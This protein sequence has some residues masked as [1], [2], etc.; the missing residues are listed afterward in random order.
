ML[1][2]LF[3]MMMQ[4]MDKQLFFEHMFGKT[5]IRIDQIPIT[6]IDEMVDAVVV[7]EKEQLLLRGI[8][9]GFVEVGFVRKSLENTVLVKKRESCFLHKMNS[10]LFTIGEPVNFNAYTFNDGLDDLRMQHT[11]KELG[12]CYT[13]I[14]TYL[15]QDKGINTIAIPAFLKKTGNSKQNK[16][17]IIIKV[18]LNYLKDNA[19]RY[20]CIHLF[21]KKIKYIDVYKKGILKA[22]SSLEL[23]NF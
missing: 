8:K 17:L 9:S 15:A 4:G 23:D 13:N 20:N 2:F 19:D 3:I 11:Q 5:L 12:E 7:G 1:S 21:V 14:L 16:A 18:L 10:S 22:V 6:K